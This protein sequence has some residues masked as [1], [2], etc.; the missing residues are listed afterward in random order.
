[1]ERLTGNW[2]PAAVGAGAFWLG[3]GAFVWKALTEPSTLPTMIGAV[4][5]LIAAVAQTLTAIKLRRD[6]EAD[7]RR[8]PGPN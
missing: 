3:T 1:M 4:C 8:P 6:A 2:R 7:A 5:F